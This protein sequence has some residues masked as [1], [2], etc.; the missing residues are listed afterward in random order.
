VKRTFAP[1]SEWLY[2]KVY[3][4]QASADSVLLNA[5]APV[6]RAAAAENLADTWFFIRYGD[7]SWHLRVRFHGEP[8][9]LVR[10][11]LPRLHEALAPLLANGLVWRTQLDTYERELERYGGGAGMDLSEQIFCADSDAV[12][13]IVETVA[14]DE[15]GTA[16]WQLALRGADMLLDDFGLTLPAKRQQMEAM[17]DGYYRELKVDAAGRRSLGQSFRKERRILEAVL[18][19][20]QDATS[21]LKDG[22]EWLARRS[23]RIVPI[24]KE[25]QRL[26]VP[27]ALSNSISDLLSS[28]IHMHTNRVLP[29]QGRR[30][31]VVIYD[32]LWRLYDSRLARQAGH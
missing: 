17:R 12:L 13:G 24:A 6:I 4:G 10:Q 32:H 1:G 8:G 14:G 2:L 11:L 27:G 23:A 5:L 16:R 19:R 21:R 26:A 18:D 31:E 28:Y 20:S 3:T 29:S 15:D 22:L 30:Q 7:P 25:L 9:A